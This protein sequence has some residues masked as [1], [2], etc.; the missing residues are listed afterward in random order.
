MAR[1]GVSLRVPPTA[2]WGASGA[3]GFPSARSH[4]RPHSVSC[5]RDPAV[6]ASAPWHRT[7]RVRPGPA[8]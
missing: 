2:L 6:A 8:G 5:A 3:S 1:S 7:R 4:L